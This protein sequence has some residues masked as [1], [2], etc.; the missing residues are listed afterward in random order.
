MIVVD[1]QNH[2][3]VYMWAEWSG[4]GTLGEIIHIWPMKYIR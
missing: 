3:T 4:G 2:E 1:V